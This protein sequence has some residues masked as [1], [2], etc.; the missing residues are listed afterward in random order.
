MYYLVP[1]KGFFFSLRNERK[2]RRLGV[3]VTVLVGKLLGLARKIMKPVSRRHRLSADIESSI[4]AP[5]RLG[6]EGTP[7][8]ALQ[9]PRREWGNHFFLECSRRSLSSNTDTVHLTWRRVG[10][11]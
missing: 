9:Y 5:V 11:L 3:T 8:I 2:L 10:P 6:S 4:V 1:M 7:T